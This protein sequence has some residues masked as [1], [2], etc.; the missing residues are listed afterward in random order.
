MNYS[1]Q[2]PS[3]V[4]TSFIPLRHGTEVKFYGFSI[5]RASAEVNV[6][7]QNHVKRKWTD[8]N[9]IQ[10]LVASNY[11][12][13]RNQK[14]GFVLPLQLRALRISDLQANRNRCVISAWISRTGT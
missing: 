7:E 14:P 1:S 9:A 4:I 10:V 3:F 5:K 2:F 8:K 13:V 12:P 11:E 6:T